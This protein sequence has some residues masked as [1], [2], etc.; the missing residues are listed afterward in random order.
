MGDMI[1]VK[2]KIEISS[3]K[4]KHFVVLQ[5]WFSPSTNLK[6]TCIKQMILLFF[7]GKPLK[8]VTNKSWEVISSIISHD[9]SMEMV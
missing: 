8:K 5:E 1:C 4:S 2:I 3:I 9:A 7:V 6:R